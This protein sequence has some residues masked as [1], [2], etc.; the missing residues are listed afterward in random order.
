MSKGNVK[1]EKIIVEN[2]TD[3]PMAEILELVASIVAQGRVSDSGRQYCYV[4]IFR[5]G[6]VITATRDRRSDRFVAF[7]DVRVATV[8]PHDAQKKDGIPD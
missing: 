1:M 6:L 5:E 8:K 2:R 7:L 3:R 4:S